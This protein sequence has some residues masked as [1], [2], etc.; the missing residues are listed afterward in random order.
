MPIGAAFKRWTYSVSSER[1][2]RRHFNL[3]FRRLVGDDLEDHRQIHSQRTSDQHVARPDQSVRAQGEVRE[4]DHRLSP[5]GVLRRGT[6]HRED[7]VTLVI[8]STRLDTHAYKRE[9]STNKPLDSAD[10]F[11][12]LFILSIIPFAL[13]NSAD[14]CCIMY[15]S[16]A[17]RAEK[18]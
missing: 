15:C 3:S 9:T 13:T 11:T 12:R 1:A 18:S 4:V 16:T 14:C 7:E 17:R 6:Q 8:D 10:V 5:G 2:T